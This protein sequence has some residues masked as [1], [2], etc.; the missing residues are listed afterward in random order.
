MIVDQTEYEMAAASMVAAGGLAQQYR[1]DLLARVGIVFARREPRLPA[2][3][4][5]QA[6]SSDMPRKNG[7]Q[8]DQVIHIPWFGAIRSSMARSLPAYGT[9]IRSPWRYSTRVR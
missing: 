3:R 6:L 1:A 7:W 4:Y 8:I 9:G 2:G 5:V